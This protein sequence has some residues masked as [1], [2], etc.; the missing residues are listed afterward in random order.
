MNKFFS[1][2]ILLFLWSGVNAT[3]IAPG[4]FE[5]YFKLLPKPQKVEFSAGRGFSPASLKLLHLD[6]LNQRPAVEQLLSAL[7][8]SG[9]SGKGVLT[10]SLKQNAKLPASPEGYLLE[11]KNGQ[12]T[13]SAKA[14]AGL[15]YGCQTLLQLLED[16]RDQQIEIP[17]CTI[18]DFPSVPY[19][20]VHLDL[21]HHLD[22]IGYYY[23]LIDGLARVKINAVIVEFEDKLRYREAPVVGASHAISIE[24]FAAISR[25]AKE[26]NIEIS[27]LVQGLGHASFILK[28]DEYKKLRENPQSDWSFSPL[29]SA[30]YELQFSLYRDAMAAT[31]GGKYLHVGGDEVADLGMSELSK[32][33]GM[34]PF[35]LQMYWLNKV[36]AFASANNR[37]PIFWDDMQ[38]KLAGLYQTTYDR[39]V[40]NSTVDSLWKINRQ[41]LDENIGLFPKNCIY[42][43]WSYDFPNIPGNLNA[44][45]WYNS[46]GLKS[47]AATAAQFYWPLMPAHHSNFQSIKEF[48]KITIDKKLDG[49]LCTAWDDAS[50]HL[51]TGW[52][53]Y[54]NFASLSWNFQDINMDDSHSMFRHR[55]YSPALNNNSFEFQD[56]L[57][58]SLTFWENALLDSG[59][60]SIKPI[61]SYLIELP[62]PSKPGEWSKKY[63]TKIDRAK[64]EAERY[65]L[66]KERIRKSINLARRGHYSLEIMNQINELQIY[67]ANLILLLEKYDNGK[68]DAEK[69]NTKVKVSGY[70]DSFSSIRRQ[71][72][73]VYSKTRLLNNPKDYILDQN[74]HS[75][76][77]NMT[78]NTGWMF[79]CE[80]AFNEKI[81]GW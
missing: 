45:D 37:I 63:K 74:Y 59:W 27:P 7:P 56:T 5:K 68:T 69:K 72:E 62:N 66:I 24:E 58:K 16:S 73:D 50:P 6:G 4:D 1:I 80:L 61:N 33:S 20:A 18:T 43:R 29:D 15:F 21:K 9:A 42:M 26:R 31:P 30:T 12:I 10:L 44:I 65:S 25:Y 57:E 71:L 36:C 52:R 70:A 23:N 51:E 64:E 54:Y 67:S 8:L 46:H 19:R 22:I 60:R 47:M 13:I 41:K 14:A 28:H 32:K 11:I 78:N 48:C 38:W 77:A 79:T 2:A 76:L 49:I 55:F 53:G 81:K 17:A 39:E 35:E 34:N 40:P 75:H 3:P